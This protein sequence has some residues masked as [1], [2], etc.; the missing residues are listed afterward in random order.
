[1]FNQSHTI[2]SKIKISETMKGR[3]P[4]NFYEMQKKGWE[5]N[6]G[7]TSWMSGKFHSIKTKKKMSIAHK[8]KRLSKVIREKMSKTHKA[9][10]TE[11]MK[12]R[13]GDSLKKYYDKIGRKI[14][15]YHCQRWYNKRKE[16]YKRDDY[17]CQECGRTSNELKKL[18]LKLHCHHIVSISE[19]EKMFENS[20]LITLCKECHYEKHSKLA[21]INEKKLIKA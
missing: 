3:M 4:K 5:S 11:G 21:F 9:I 14:S 18:G 15:K 7:K 16:I 2:E 20:N 6:K 8:G 17:T 13:I 10:M 1:M 12:K 19:K